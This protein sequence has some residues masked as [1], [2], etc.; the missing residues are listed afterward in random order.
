MAV[1]LIKECP[2]VQTLSHRV[3]QQRTSI[4]TTLLHIIY[5][6]LYILFMTYYMLCIIYHKLCIIYYMLYIIYY[7]LY[8]IYYISY[9][10]SY[11][12]YIIY[13]I[14][15]ALWWGWLHLW[16]WLRCHY[17]F[18]VWAR[19]SHYS[20]ILGETSCYFL[21]LKIRSFLNAQR[22]PMTQVLVLVCPSSTISSDRVDA[23]PCTQ[24]MV[25]QINSLL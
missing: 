7:I 21:M 18:L 11:I 22:P 14:P 9:I 17:L 6:I 3:I 19:V 5:Y 20:Y 15:L 24:E 13:Y 8:I 25:H 23:P 2:V 12:L 4:S 16:R 1:P 10:I